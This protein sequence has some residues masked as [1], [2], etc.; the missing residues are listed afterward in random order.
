P[1]LSRLLVLLCLPIVWSCSTHHNNPTGPQISTTLSSIGPQ[2]NARPDSLQA[3]EDPEL[4]AS[5]EIQDE[6]ISP[7]DLE[8]TAN[9]EIQDLE[10]MGAWEDGIAMTPKGTLIESDFPIVINRQ[11]EYYLDLFQNQQRKVFTG[12]LTRSGRYLPM[13]QQELA[14]AGLP[15]D[16]AYL[17]MIE[18]GFKP[19]AFSTASA[20]GLWQFM[21]PTAGRFGLQINSYV[22]ERRDAHRSTQAAINYL[23][24]LYSQFG[25]W[26]VTV[27]AYNAGE[28]RINNGLQKYNCDNFWDLAK[29][30]YLPLETKRYVPQLIAA[31]MI[32]KY[33]H[34]Y[35]FDNIQYDKPLAFETVPVPPRT[36]LAAVAAASNT[37]ADT[38]YDLNR[39][40]S[41]KQV[42]PGIGSYDLR[43]PP[44]TA[45]LVA[46]NLPRVHATVATLFKDHVVGRRDTL[47][48]ICAKYNISKINLLKA[49]NLRKAKLVA[50]TILR[51]PYQTAQYA[52]LSDKEIQQ[53]AAA[54]KKT[55]D[56][57][58]HKVKAGDSISQIAARYGSSTKEIMTLNN[59]TTKHVLKIGQQ[60][61]VAQSSKTKAASTPLRVADASK[62][63]SKKREIIA[64]RSKSPAKQK[65]PTAHYQVKSGDSLWTIAQ[66]FDLSP[67]DLKKWNNLEGNRIAPGLKLLIKSKS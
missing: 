15:Q 49:N 26:Y 59:L 22:D 9:Q 43:V 40:L 41:K 13:I 2:E 6:D 29:E 37:P 11:V 16:L 19:N 64:S 62:N 10:K 58:V 34:D 7:P 44:G 33:P 47:N 42:P 18:S 24:T 48:K 67:D 39:H 28:G 30:D 17:A 54:T 25:K 21:A 12:W 50:G 46:N 55:Q 4:T 56:V 5:N 31:I 32:A 35:G 57:T 65:A 60:L 52:L 38:L 53:L 45:R 23:S 36:E 3:Q 51:I 8:A 20:T 27:A 14:E 66:Q 63:T 61:T 1:C